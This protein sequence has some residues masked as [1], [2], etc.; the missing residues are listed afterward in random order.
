MHCRCASSRRAAARAGRVRRVPLR[1]ARCAAAR[2]SRR[3]TSARSIAAC[4]LDRG[5]RASRAQGSPATRKRP[6]TR[7]VKS[8]WPATAAHVY[9]ECARIWNPIH[10]D[11]AYARAAGLPDI[12][13]HGTAT[14]ALLHF[15]P[16]EDIGRRAGAS[17]ARALAG[18]PGMVLMP[19]T[20][21]VHAARDGDAIALRDPATTRARRSSTAGGFC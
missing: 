9:T 15:G 16:A 20:L 18:S 17:A 19:S 8:R 7:S 13:L 6:R 12:I 14:L 4:E 1:D 5:D 11:V 21:S 3:P 10:T 2:R